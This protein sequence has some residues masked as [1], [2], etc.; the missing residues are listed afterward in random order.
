MHKLQ[1]KKKLAAQTVRSS[2]N[3]CG[4]M[5]HKDYVA[6]I[7]RVADGKAQAYG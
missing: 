2:L 4:S 3:F 5:V 7:V 1:S 6:N